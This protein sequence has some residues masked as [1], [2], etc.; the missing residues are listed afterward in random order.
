MTAAVDRSAADSH[1]PESTDLW[2]DHDRGARTG[3]AEAVYDRAR[4]RHRAPRPSQACSG[5]TGL[6]PSC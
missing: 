6:S 4:V 5:A 1:S 3:V 2:L